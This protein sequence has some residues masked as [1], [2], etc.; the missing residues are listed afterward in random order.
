MSR[1]LSSTVSTAITQNPTKPV[2]LL[3]IGFSLESLACTWG[4]NIS[5]NSEN[6]VAS[7]IEVKNLTARGATLEFPNG[8]D[9]AW[10][11]LI[12][13]ESTRDRPISIYEFH[14]DYSTSPHGTDAVLVFT[15][16]MDEAEITENIKVTVIESSQA[17]QF[18]PD[19]IGPPVF[20]FLPVAGTRIVW[21]DDVIE[22]K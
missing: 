17:R 13:N 18:P 21:G 16:I 14:T 8:E 11:A 12:L 15:G 22:V 2:Y 4:S 7:G 1:T 9:D 6:W 3:R 10:L 20:N 19:S 5:W